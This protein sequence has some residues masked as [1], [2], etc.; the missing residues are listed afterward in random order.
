MSKE[1]EFDDEFDEDYDGEFD[2]ITVTFDNGEER[3][4]AIIEVFEAN[5][6]VYAAIV[7][8]D[9]LFEEETEVMIYEFVENEDGESEI[10][11]IESDEEYQ[12]ASAVFDELMQSYEDEE[13]DEE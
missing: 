3:D 7:P 6:K 11:Y 4:C 10:F 13:D 5:D 12:A 9:E 2:I 1:L 8:H